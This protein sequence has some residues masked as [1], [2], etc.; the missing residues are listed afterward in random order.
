MRKG[1]QIWWVF[2][3]LLDQCQQMVKTKVMTPL[4]EFQYG[5]MACGELTDHNRLHFFQKYQM[6]IGVGDCRPTLL[7]NSIC[8]S[9]AIVL[10]NRLRED[11]GYSQA[12]PINFHF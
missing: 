11:E 3:V 1:L 10:A 5:I 6:A 9:I 4:E 12:I 7:S 2:D 8:L